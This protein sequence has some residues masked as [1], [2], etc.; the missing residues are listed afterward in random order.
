M[1]RSGVV[2]AGMLGIIFAATAV[3]AAAPS[4]NPL[5]FVDWANA[6]VPASVC[7]GQGSVRLHHSYGLVSSP[8]WPDAWNSNESAVM[9]DQV[10]VAF[11][12]P[13]RYGTVMADGRPEA[14]VPIWCTNGG[15][16]ADGQLGQGL[17]VYHETRDGP[18][19]TGIIATS[20]STNQRM[21]YFN[22]DATRLERGR[23]TLDE[24]FYGPDDS[25]CCPT[26]R[27]QGTWAVD[28]GTLAQRASRVT[29]EPDP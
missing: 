11:S 13:V 4:A 5:K 18:A 14:F 21:A 16:T 8:R 22:N 17:V 19:V 3:V 10:Q 29:R 15:G 27:A 26:G 9:A 28:N 20:P 6:A 24:L 23:V 2:A 1:F 7:G 25:P 12:G